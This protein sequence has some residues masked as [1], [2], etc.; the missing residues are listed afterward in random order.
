MQ[1]PPDFLI[2]PLGDILVRRALDVEPHQFRRAHAEQ[3]KAAL[4]EAIDQFLGDRTRLRQNAEPAERIFALV[5]GQHAV[6]NARPAN[7]MKAVAA[8]DE[9]AVELLRFAGVLETNFRR[10]GQPLDTDVVDVEENLAAVGEPPGDEV[11]HHLVLAID[12]DALADE[13]FEI[14]PAKLVVEA[15]IDAAMHQPL[16]L[17]TFAH[18]G[19]DQEIGGPVLDHAGADARLDIVAAA[20]F[21]DDGFDAFEMQEM[22]QHQPRRCPRRRCRPVCA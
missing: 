12:Q 2:R 6:R 21:E 22:R 14:D 7:A 3:G 11:L 18:A 20:V 1:L 5:V 15:E 19:R 4:V 17:H 16:A 10:A 13:R 9:I 8:A